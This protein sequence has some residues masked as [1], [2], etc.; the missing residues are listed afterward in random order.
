M[1]HSLGALACGAELAP[2]LGEG[3]AQALILAD[4]ALEAGDQ[5]AKEHVRTFGEMVA[6][7]E[8]GGKLR[9]LRGL[10]GSE[11]LHAACACR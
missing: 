11:A 7:T 9:R 1:H 8:G 4:D 2:L 6:G 10:R 5:P 3:F